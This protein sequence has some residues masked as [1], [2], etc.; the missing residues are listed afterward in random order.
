[1]SQLTVEVIQEGPLR[2]VEVLQEGPRGAR[3]LPGPPG[4]SGEL[5]MTAGI[6]GRESGTGAPQVLTLGSGLSIINGALTATGGGAGSG[7]VTSVALSAPLGFVVNSS[8]ITSSGT[9]ALSYA[10]GYSLPTTASQSQWD[11]AYSERNQWNG[12]VSGLV[13]AT[14]RASLGLGSAATSNT[15]DFATAAQGALAAT[16]VQPAALA[17]YVQSSDSRLSDSREWIATTVTQADAEAGVATARA[18]WTVQRVWQAITAWWSASSAKAKLDGIA[19]GATANSS[20]ATLLNR[21]NHTGT[22]A[23]STI[24]D[25][26]AAGRTLLTSANA[27]TQLASLGAQKAITSGTAPPSGGADGDIYLQYTP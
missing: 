20:D 17:L 11:T 14:G 13:P 22:Q 19:S 1:M 12:G 15:T 24:S 27:A 21:A 9:L 2:F 4:T 25:S 26:T 5:T 8:P 3:G 6:L 23:A 10:A 7:T 16:A 18:A